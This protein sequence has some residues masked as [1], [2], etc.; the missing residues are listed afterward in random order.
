MEAVQ[1]I[2]VTPAFTLTPN[3]VDL[4]C[5]PRSFFQHSY[6]GILDFPWSRAQFSIDI[7]LEQRSFEELLITLKTNAARGEVV[8]V[9]PP[10]AQGYSF[11]LDA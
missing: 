4:K 1:H 5:A 9:T 11:H 8:V 2:P 6:L 3:L 10:H 7:Q